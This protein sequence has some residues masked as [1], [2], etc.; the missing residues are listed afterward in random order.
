M[1]KKDKAHIS[2]VMLGYVDSGKSTTLG[3][4][5]YK[6]GVIDDKTID[7]FEKETA[8]VGMPSFK[9]AWAVNKLKNE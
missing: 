1:L 9:Y 4:L 5:L 6:C 8:E 7:K 2:V 3:H